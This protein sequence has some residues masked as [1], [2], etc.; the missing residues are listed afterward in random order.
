MQ[1]TEIYKS[2]QGESRFTGLPCIFIRTTGCNLRCVWCDSE[3]AFYGGKTKTLDEIMT[4]VAGFNCKLV[5]ITGGEPLLQKDTPELAKRL[6]DKGYQVLVETSGERDIAVLSPD[7]IKIMDIKCPGSGEVERNHLENLSH[8][9][10]ND[11]VKFVIQ[12]RSDYE[13]AAEFI[14]RYKLDSITSILFSPV[15]GTMNTR[16]LVDWILA[17]NLNVRFQL[18]LHKQVWPP[19]TKGV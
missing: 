19:D 3:Y 16:K 10:H 1:I 13:W 14:S 9:T 11:E 5:E 12:D 6:V 8:L 2:I 7:V 17:D 15:F 4:T 18:Q